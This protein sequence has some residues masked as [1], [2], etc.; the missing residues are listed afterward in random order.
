MRTGHRV[1]ERLLRAAERNGCAHLVLVDPDRTTPRRAAELARECES[2]ET[3]A[4]LFGSSTPLERDPAP[5]IHALRESYS[6]PTVLFP[7]GAEQVR[8]DIDAV[9]FLSLLSGRDPRYL[10]GEQVAAAP[11]LLAAGVE[12]IPTAYL[13][14]GSDAGGSVARATGTRPL[15]VEPAS[16]VV[17]HAQAAAC[18][19]FS[20]A[21]LEAGSG[22]PAPL[23]ASLVRRVAEAAP[24]AIVVG[25]GIR[26]PDQAAALAAAGARFIVTGTVHE[27]G[28]AVH[29]FTRAIH[30][31]APALS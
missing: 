8:A 15:P 12:A 6:G 10:V 30:A 19:G 21:Y 24:I 20:L 5:V 31:P 27:E 11:R 25:G 26:T 14:V 29:P 3:D 13:L 1:L 28:L 23:P 9:L 4:I 18:L 7:G 2:A 16:D 17:A 22:A